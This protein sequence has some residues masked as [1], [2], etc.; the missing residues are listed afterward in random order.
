MHCP[1]I[2]VYTVCY[3]TYLHI[4][5]SLQLY[6]TRNINSITACILSL[7]NFHSVLFFWVPFLLTCTVR[8][9]IVYYQETLPWY[10]YFLSALRLVAHHPHI[11]FPVLRTRCH[12]YHVTMYSAV[13][14][15]GTSSHLQARCCHAAL[16]SICVSS[17]S[18]QPCVSIPTSLPKMSNR[19]TVLAKRALVCI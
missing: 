12:E 14:G 3:A 18:H 5:S 4:L 1:Q 6:F 13:S 2:Y 7:S 15:T 16:Q 19:Y 17:L 8:L 10:G 9:D 11:L